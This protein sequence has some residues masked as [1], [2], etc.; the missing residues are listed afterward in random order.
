MR[1]KAKTYHKQP[2]RQVLAPLMFPLFSWEDKDN[3]TFY[4]LLMKYF[5]PSDFRG[6]TPVKIVSGADYDDY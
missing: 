2:P 4:I 1:S 3:K 6:V 5:P